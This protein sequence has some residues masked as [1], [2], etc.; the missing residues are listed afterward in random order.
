MSYLDEM[1]IYARANKIPVI[2]RDT[3]EYLENLCREIKPKRIL[4]IGMAIGYSASCMLLSSEADIVECEASIPNIQ[5]AKVNFDILG[6]THRV[7]IVEGDCM[8]TLP[9]VEGKFD[10]IFLDGPK[11]KYPE[12]LPLVLPKLS[13]TGVLVCDNVLFRGMVLDGEPLQWPRFERTVIA[14]REFI[15]ML[16]NNDE[17]DTQILHIGDGLAVARYK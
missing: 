1:E 8:N 16:Q 12:I 14:L 17:L 5:L 11:G 4:E 6:L 3:R 7:T 15:Q 9:S 10:L 2:L 13:K